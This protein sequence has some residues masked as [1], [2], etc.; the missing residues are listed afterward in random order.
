MSDSQDQELH[1]NESVVV[2][3]DLFNFEA[4]PGYQIENL[5]EQAELEGPNGEFLVVTSY[6]LEADSDEPTQQAFVQNITSA[7]LQA[8]DEPDLKIASSLKKEVNEDSVPVWR[9][10]AL[11]NDGHHFFDQ[12]SAI[13]GNHAIVVTLEGE[14]KVQRSSSAAVEESVHAIEFK[15]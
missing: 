14:S 8:A 9:L 10:Q 3:T 15:V 4:P 12:Y 13:K 1:R 11:S 6:S 7:M 5:D 2:E